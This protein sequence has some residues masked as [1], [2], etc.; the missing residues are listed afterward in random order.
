M[1]ILVFVLTLIALKGLD[2]IELYDWWQTERAGVVVLKDPESSALLN[3]FVTFAAFALTVLSAVAQSFSFVKSRINRRFR[4]V[5]PESGT[6]TRVLAV[7]I[8]R[9]IAIV[10]HQAGRSFCHSA[11]GMPFELT[12][13]VTRENLTVPNFD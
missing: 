2:A 9:L 12:R 7:G 1:T 4:S 11:N 10:R 5:G 6:A 3:G 8:D 13:W